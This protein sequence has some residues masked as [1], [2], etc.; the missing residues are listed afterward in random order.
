MKMNADTFATIQSC[1]I[2]IQELYPN[3]IANYKKAGKSVQQWRWDLYHAACDRNLIDP[4][5][6]YREGLN[7]AHVDT[8]LRSIT[9]TK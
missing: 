2:S 4:M 7:D 8:A 5:L 6:V 9:G 1:L 3:S